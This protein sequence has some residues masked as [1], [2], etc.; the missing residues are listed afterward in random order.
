MKPG[1]AASRRS[2]GVELQSAWAI[3]ISAILRGGRWNAR[4]ETIAALQARS[5]FLMSPGISTLKAGAASLGSSPAATAAP[6]A[7]RISS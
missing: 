4:A 6:I 7:D 3:R 2:N 1:P 5:P